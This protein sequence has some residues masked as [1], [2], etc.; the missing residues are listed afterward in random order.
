MKR[1][2]RFIAALAIACSAAACSQSDSGVTTRVKAKFAQDDLVKAHEID[3]TTREGVVTLSGEVETMEARRQA[4]RLARETQ[5]VTNVVDDLKVD[6][7]ATSGEA[8]DV[9]VDVDVDVDN[10]I[11]RGARKT[12]DAIRKGAEE[13]ADA[14]KRTGKAVSDAV[15][16][17]DRDSDRDGK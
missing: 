4:V 7:A 15:T 13:T 9:D 2:N 16:D 14:A 5:G 3:V 1:F 12:G 17:D 8:D 10:D 11:E 6:V